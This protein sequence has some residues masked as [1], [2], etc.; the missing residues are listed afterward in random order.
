MKL[1]FS[2]L[3]SGLLLLS[4]SHSGSEG[5]PAVGYDMK[6]LVTASDAIIVGM[7]LR[8]TQTRNLARLVSDP[9]QEAKDILIL[10]QDYDV[11]VDAVLKGPVISSSLVTVSLAKWHGI[12]Q[13]TP[14]ADRDYIPFSIGQS[15][16]LFLR[17]L[18]DG[19]SAFGQ[20]LEPF[21]FKIDGA[22]ATAESRW[23]RAADYFPSRAKETL[24]A[25]IRDV[26]R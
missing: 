5:S 8:S 25:Q 16:V 9:T 7:V 3:V 26:T 6:Q 21:R 15:Y 14:A 20:S 1:L 11:R 12:P 18:N 22:N 2:I 17:A 10:G 13:Q 23:G 4:C 19:T 24:L